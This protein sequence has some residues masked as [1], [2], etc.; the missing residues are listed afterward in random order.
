M[1][2]TLALI[3]TPQLAAQPTSPSLI[4]DQP[5]YSLWHVGGTVTVTASKLITNQTYYL[6]LQR[7]SQVSS[8]YATVIGRNGT[9]RILLPIAPTD[10]SGT[11]RASLSTSGFTDTDLAVVHFGIFGT[12]A[13]SYERTGKVVISGG[14]FAPNSTITIGL[15][16]AGQTVN[17]FPQSI[18]SQLDG[19]FNYT[20]KLP[21]SANVG[22]LTV[23]VTGPDYDNIGVTSSVSAT[24]NVNPT[25]I[26]ISGGAPPPATVE[27]TAKISVS[28]LLTYP[29]SSGVTTASAGSSLSVVR[30]SDAAV[31]GE[32]PLQLSNSSGTWSAV[33]VP[34]R[35]ATLASYHFELAASSFIDGYGNH[36]QGPAVDS[37]SFAVNKANV[38][39]SYPANSTLERA[40]DAHLVVGAGQYH[41]GSNFEN[42]TV[43]SGNVVDAEGVSHALAFNS[44]L[45]VLTGTMKVPVNATL[46]NWRIVGTMTDLYGNTASG[47][48]VIQIV[49]ANL[50]F[51]VDTPPTE[52]TTMMKVTARVSYPDGTTV[53]PSLVA[54][55]FN[56]TVSQGNFTWRSGMSF[57]DT[58]AR[59]TA[60][61]LVPINATLGD[62]SVGMVL[63]DIYGNGGGFNTTARVTPARF[64]ITLPQ[65]NAKVNPGNI[66][67]IVAS[68][69]YPNGTFLNTY[70]GVVFAYLTNSSGTYNF[71]MTYDVSNETWHAYFT[72]PDLG[73]SF[74]KAIPFSFSAADQFGNSGIAANAYELDVGA[75]SGALVLATV[76]GGL[77]PIGLL[78]WAIATVSKRRRKHKP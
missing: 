71:P 50:R 38:S 68:V 41:D 65:S 37:A 2:I 6:W 21:P 42:V 59:W 17:G 29:D 46:G 66:V 51:Q 76:V 15:A 75:G 16:T 64:R 44:T 27:R 25:S 57:N 22:V 45:N 62:Y 8:R 28:Y 35:N 54:S 43:A 78:G 55:G 69:Q 73:I 14:G 67:D 74:G 24:M 39:L 58:T 23:N 61:Y 12:D 32:V 56:I 31:I 10:A 63:Q 9:S 3:S 53:N 34:P 13:R 20:F 19:G 7:P 72:A 30:D 26:K 49:K 4:T 33:W 36:G 52:R 40:E 77:V 48:F 18:R 60:G 5:V 47:E 1:F 70:G 11:Y